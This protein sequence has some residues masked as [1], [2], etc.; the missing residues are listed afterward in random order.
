MSRIKDVV[1][2]VYAC[3]MSHKQTFILGDGQKDS[4]ADSLNSRR[5][6][7]YTLLVGI[8][9]CLH[10]K[11]T[12]LVGFVGSMKLDFVNKTT[13]ENAS[14]RSYVRL[15]DYFKNFSFEEPV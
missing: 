2:W 8:V 12:L 7:E 1:D 14:C 4:L 15:M 3:D 5:L 13:F 10:N 9:I 6:C 11:T